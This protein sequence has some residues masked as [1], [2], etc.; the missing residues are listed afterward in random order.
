VLRLLEFLAMIVFGY[1]ALLI[2]L[3]VLEFL[4]DALDWAGSTIQ[5]S[6]RP[7]PVS[8]VRYHCIHDVLEGTYCYDCEQDKLQGK[9]ITRKERY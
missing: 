7:S 8:T 5:A 3:G 4:G 6:L 2:L 9:A 1:F